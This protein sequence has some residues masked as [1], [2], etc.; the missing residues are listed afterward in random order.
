LMLQTLPGVTCRIRCSNFLICFFLMPRCYVCVSCSAAYDC[1][2][3]V[4]TPQSILPS[5]T[6]R[7]VLPVGQR[8]RSYVQKCFAYTFGVGIESRM[9]KVY[10]RGSVSG[11][12]SWAVHEWY[13]TQ[14]TRYPTAGKR[15]SGEGL[16]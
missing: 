10:E 3:L 11:G 15:P 1:D 14:S 2:D 6:K 7:G 5:M 8:S 16:E 13:I 9:Y 4:P 12:T